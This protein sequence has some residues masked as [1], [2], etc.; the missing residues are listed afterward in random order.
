M[1]KLEAIPFKSAEYAQ[2]GLDKLRKG[3]DFRWFSEN[4]EGKAERETPGL[5]TFGD[6]TVTTNSLMPGLKKA[7]TGVKT[8]EYRLYSDPGGIV[9]VVHVKDVILAGVQPYEDVSAT[10]RKTLYALRLNE[11]LED[12]ASK[13]RAASKV[14]IL[15]TV[16][17]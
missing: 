3:M 2:T 8:D 6:M 12:W 16:T 5:L 1:L 9:Y 11:A 15:A 4:A 10:V 17:K 14:A 7:L 13:L